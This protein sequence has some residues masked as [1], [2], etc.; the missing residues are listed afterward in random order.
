M[1]AGLELDMLLH[2]L[3]LWTLECTGSSPAST[4]EAPGVSK[5]LLKLMAVLLVTTSAYGE[6]L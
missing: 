1:L 6:G 3:S 2:T 4:E 5:M